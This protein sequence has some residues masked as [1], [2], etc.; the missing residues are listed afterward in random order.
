MSSLSKSVSFKIVT[1]AGTAQETLD[2]LNDQAEKLQQPIELK[3][4]GDTG[5]AAEQIGS[6]DDALASLKD[7]LGLANEG[8][9]GLSQASVHVGE[10]LGD[11][12]AVTDS[13]SDALKGL[14]DV[15]AS[16]REIEAELA[17]GQQVEADAARVLTNSYAAEARAVKALSAAQEELAGTTDRTT[18]SEEA[19]DAK[20]E[21][22]AGLFEGLSGK[23]KLA[24]LGMAAGIAYGTVAA[25]KFQSELETLHTQAGVSQSALKGLGDGVLS[26]AGQV[27]FSPD[28]L[29]EAL[30]HV[31]SSFASV[32]IKGPAALNLLKTAAEGAAVGHANLTDT[33]NALDAVIASGVGGI[34]N[35]SQAMGALNSIVGAG[36]MTMEDLAQAMGTGV[37]AVAKSY[38]QSIDQVGAAL[39]VFGDNNIRGAKAATDLRMAWQAVQAPLTTA[40]TALKQLGLTDTTLADTMTHKGLSAAIA[41][42]IQHLE[43]SKIPASEWGQ[44][45][46]DIFGK[47]AGVGIGILVD[48]FSRLQSKFPDLEKGADDFGGAW[49]AQSETVSQEWKNLVSGL[50]GLVT[51]QGSVFL[52][53]TKTVLKVVDDFVEGLTKGKA[54]ALTLASVIGV[55]LAGVALKKL[56]DGLSTAVEGFKGLYEAGESAISFVGGLM[57]KMTG[58]GASAKDAAVS[59]DEL[60]AAQE[61]QATAAKEAA[62]AQDELDVAE[63]ANPLGVIILAVAALV[64]GIVLLTTHC[65]AF[66]DFW[67]DA[68]HDIQDAFDDAFKFIKNEWPLI[69]GILTGPVGL[70]VVEI[71]K[72]WNDIKTDFHDLLSDI[73]NSWPVVKEVL[74]S[75]ITEVVS[76]FEHVPGW[77]MGAVDDLPHLFEDLGKNIIIGLW[78]GI[79]SLAGWIEGKLE[80]FAS[81]IGS[82][83]KSMLGISSPSTVFHGF[84]QNIVQGLV[85]GITS[86]RELATDAVT[87]LGRS[88]SESLHVSAPNI[89]GSG[90]Y[91]SGGSMNV[92]NN[93]TVQGLVGDAGATGRQIAE[94]L[95]TYLRQTGQKQLVGA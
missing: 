93:V 36:D 27:G 42:F 91:A 83:F 62:V 74:E 51:E 78:N 18:E 49:K 50:E 15:A 2:D 56:E 24:A 57:S 8:L 23:I 13:F 44:Y 45:M 6:V 28:S 33:V 64:T 79:V 21:E 12:G 55:T 90:G 92:T 88:V 52:P 69:L 71:V 19:Q 63:D 47:K 4:A 38:G 17:E 5:E 58:I 32:G 31:E 94:S 65:K 40:G 77:I 59:T 85:L 53:I 95:N 25:V 76:F 60:T 84:G 46:T 75:P 70:A 82:W 10:S 14:G 7:E 61:E 11:A 89:T 87:S 34:K 29:V 86:A 80:G 66:R 43:A 1:D 81:D 26:L 3:V 16:V 73:K 72:H 54:P 9:D 30:Y 68:W 37:M 22:S 35:Y 39:A 41:Q 48:Q 67:K 20:T